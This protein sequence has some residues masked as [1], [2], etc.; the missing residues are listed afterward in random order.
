M[1]GSDTTPPYS[2]VWT[3]AAVGNYGVLAIAVDRTADRRK[4][5]GS[6]CRLGHGDRDEQ[7]HLARTLSASSDHAANVSSY[8]LNVYA[9]GANPSTALP[10]ATSD[11]GKPTPDGLS[12]ISVDRT[13]FINALSTGS[14]T[15][16]VRPSARAAPRQSQA[17]SFT[18]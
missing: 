12:N 1:V 10:L 4:P 16:T 2:F 5:T 13:T 18:R 3:G 7:R 14:Y 8:Q 17:T 11:L 6:R 9:Y 15:A